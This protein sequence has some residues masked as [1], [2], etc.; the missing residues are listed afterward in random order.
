MSKKLTYF[1]FAILVLLLSA[2]QSDEGTSTEN[3]DKSEPVSKQSAESDDKKKEN[4]EEDILSKFPELKEAP[5][6]PATLEENV[7]YPAGPLSKYSFDNNKKEITKE[8]DKLPKLNGKADQEVLD[9]YWR[10]WVQLF[11]PDYKD[12]KYVFEQMKVMSFGSPEITDPRYQLKDNLNVEIILDASGS[13]AALV[14]GQSKMQLAKAAIK[15]FTSSLPENT[16]VGLRVYG[17]KG[18]GSDSDKQLSCSSNELIYSFSPYMQAEFDNALNQI[19]PA[20]W[21]PVA[22]SLEHALKDLSKYPVK[23]NTN[24]VFLVS[25]GIETCGG[26][27]V[28]AAKKLKESDVSPIVNI[29]G[30]DV[31]AD[32]Q[33]QLQAAA[34]AADG[35][36]TNVYDQAGLEEEFNR[37]KEIA[38]KWKNWKIKSD[39]DAITTSYERGIMVLEITNDWS[40]KSFKEYQNYQDAILYLRDET[41][42]LTGE[43]YEYIL[44]K[45]EERRDEVIKQFQDLEKELNQ[46]NN[47]TYEEMQ[48]Q[49]DEKFK[50]N[51][52][53]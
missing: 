4:A 29:I 22:D 31:D 36:Y 19:K 26:N 39:S 45:M 17:H 2:C 8:L 10:R 38:E 46:L 30:F 14:D 7:S 6:V 35:I 21:T 13:M 16:N 49:I 9:A 42:A 50:E 28:Q 43:A 15:E 32:G 11:A 24:I 12:P 20:G 41:G 23:D 53:T 33:K 5:P 52:G 44:S 34:D 51:S 37:A 3:K 27:P 40:D 47:Q 48:K 25:D 18:S 1:I